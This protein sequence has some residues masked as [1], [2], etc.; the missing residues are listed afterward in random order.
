[1]ERKNPLSKESANLN[2]TVTDDADFLSKYSEADKPVISGEV[3][4]FMENVAKA[5]HPDQSFTL[6]IKSACIDETEKPKYKKA[7]K[8]YYSAKREEADRDLKRK[9]WIAV[10]FAIIGI[11]ALAIMFILSSLDLN[12]I[13]KECIDI[14]AWVFLW[15][16]VDQ[17]FIERS[18]ILLTCKRYK[19]FTEAE[20]NFV[21]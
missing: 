2:I 14:F 6:N 16:A 20:I 9:T 4:E 19:R 1:M 18:G 12:E 10:T 5:Y 8:N 11:V 21:C 3:A 15:E 13:W 7:F 17:F